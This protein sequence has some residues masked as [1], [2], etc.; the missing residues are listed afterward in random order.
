MPKQPRAICPVCGREVTLRPDG[1]LWQHR[2]R[3][4]RGAPV[5]TG[6]G[7]DP[8]TGRDPETSPHGG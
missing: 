8:T 5:C 7:A 2:T 1:K 4:V 3:S 6:S